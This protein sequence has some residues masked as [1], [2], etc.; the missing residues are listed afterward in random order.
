MFGFIFIFSAPANNGTLNPTPQTKLTDPI[1]ARI[2]RDLNSPSAAA[3]LRANK[4]LKS[5]TFRGKIYGIFDVPHERQDL[6]TDE[7]RKPYKPKTVQEVFEKCKVYVEVRTGDD[8][9]TAGI[10]NMLLREGITVNAKLYKD[11]TH[12]IFKDGLLSTYKNAI[13]MGIPITS[14]LWIDACKAQ[15][16]LVDPEKFKISNI[17]RYVH[18]ELYKR[19]RRQKSM[20][21]EITMMPLVDQKKM[22]LTQSASKDGPTDFIDKTVVEPDDAEMELTLTN[23]QTSL[24]PVSIKE[25]PKQGPSSAMISDFR[26]LTTYTPNLMEQT[27]ITGKSIVDHRRTL[28]S[29]Q[30][31]QSS[32]IESASTPSGFSGNSSNTIIFNS[33]NRIAKGSRRSVFDISM[34]ILELNCKSLVEHIDDDL[35]P[36]SQ[37][38]KKPERLVSAVKTVEKLITQFKP[39]PVIRKRKLFSDVSYD[40]IELGKENLDDSLKTVKNVTK[41]DKSLQAASKTPQPA[42]KLK[43]QVERRKTLAYF[44]TE[45]PKEA[46]NV[47]KT[48][49]KSAES[50]QKY[51]VVTNMSSADKLIINDVS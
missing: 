44:K 36:K 34:N 8:N 12:V 30:P 7:E 5:P 14:I 31:T 33:V 35:Q 32:S 26:R 17:D 38:A 25:T 24:T 23:N 27:G 45:K 37:S 28:Y 16:R 40:D 21:P 42:K 51:I 43:S 29:S 6:I 11:T 2:H 47:K 4:A 10:Q 1:M 15:R 50:P 39:P 41:L 49:A 20:Q 22:A 19:L 9:R 13:K 46:V 18:P 3:R 48:P